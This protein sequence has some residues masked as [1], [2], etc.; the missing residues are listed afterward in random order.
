M[1]VTSI[2]P[3]ETRDDVFFFLKTVFSSLL[4]RVGK[5]LNYQSNKG[6]EYWAKSC[7]DV[8]DDTHVTNQQMIA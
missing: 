8:S 6:L 1:G 7:G 3:V 5:R 2:I 4:L